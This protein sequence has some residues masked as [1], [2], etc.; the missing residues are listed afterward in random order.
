MIAVG[1]YDTATMMIAM[2]IMMTV[3]L[4]R[5]EELRV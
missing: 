4:K 1:A 3:V 2:M 5:S